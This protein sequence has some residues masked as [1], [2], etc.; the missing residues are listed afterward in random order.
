[1]RVAASVRVGAV[2]AA[3]VVTGRVTQG[4]HLQAHRVPEVARG[5]GHQA[6]RVDELL[7]VL[8]D[9]ALVLHAEGRTRPQLGPDVRDLGR[10][11]RWCR[12]DQAEIYITHKHAFANN[13]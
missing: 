8:Q 7:V 10:K 1:M 6:L 2:D 3:Y 5:Q 11:P 13:K 9:T 4:L 12:P